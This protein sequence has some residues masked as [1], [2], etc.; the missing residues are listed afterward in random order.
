MIEVSAALILERGRVLICQRA[1]G[2]HHAEMWE[3]PGGKREP[4]ESGEAALKREISEELGVS[5][6]PGDLISKAHSAFGD[7]EIQLSL[8]LCSGMGVHPELREHKA[9]AWVYGEDLLGYELPEADRKMIPAIQVFLI[10]QFLGQ[11]H[12]SVMEE[13]LLK[14]RWYPAKKKRI[15]SYH[16]AD[17]VFKNH[18]ALCFFQIE[19]DEGSS[20]QIRIPFIRGRFQSWSHS[21]VSRI[22][23]YSKDDGD[24]T[25]FLDSQ[26]SNPLW[27]FKQNLIK[28]YPVQH[29]GALREK[30]LLEA[31]STVEAPVP[32][33]RGSASWQ[34][35]PYWI[36]MSL[37]SGESAWSYLLN[38]EPE[39]FV[40]QLLLV[41]TRIC[42]NLQSLHTKLK[43]VMPVRP[44][45][46]KEQWIHGDFHL[47]QVLLNED[48]VCILDFEGAPAG[49]TLE[50]S[51]PAED[52]AGLLRSVDYLLCERGFADEARG[53]WRQKLLREVVRFFDNNVDEAELR[54]FEQKRLD[55]ELEY[56]SAFR[57]EKLWIP[58]SARDIVGEGDCEK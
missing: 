22:F 7:K 17:V 55:Y 39:I 1:S 21:S 51:L 2:A 20:L 23:S 9:L 19:F 43:I 29:K 12:L 13:F 3:F 41:F 27:V 32:R 34:D 52:Y 42:Q 57:P 53:D 36:E 33:F 56:E 58:Q 11:I 18:V 14:E 50:V 8:Y 54:S 35:Q 37:E 16:L 6:E 44:A 48:R 49:G 15:Q 31:L 47:G 30:S 26:S 40:K 10:N 28:I 25:F 46:K 38:L 45:A 4:G 5:V 24:R